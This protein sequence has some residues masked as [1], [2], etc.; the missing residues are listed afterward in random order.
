MYDL[1]IKDGQV[2][3]GSGQPLR[4]ADVAISKD[5]IARIGTV[6]SK[7]AS[8]VID[9][10]GRVVSPGFIDIHSHAD[11]TLP[12]EPEAAS[13][14]HQGIT[15]AVVGH[16]GH[17]LAPLLDKT[18]TEVIATQTPQGLTLPW[19]KWSTYGS[20]LDYLMELKISVNVVPLV[21]QGTIRGSVMG[22][23]ARR[24]TSQ[25]VTRMQAEVT[26]ALEAGSFGLSTGLEYPPGSYAQLEELMQV[27]QPLAKERA[28]YFSHLR[29]EGPQLVEAVKEAV[30]VGR[31]TGALVEI[32]HLKACWPG[33]E[34]QD[35]ALDIIGQAQAEGIDVAFDVYPYLASSTSLTLVLPHWVQEGGKTLTLNRLKDETVRRQI[36]CE[37]RAGS[38][39]RPMDWTQVM[40]SGS[41]RSEDEGLFVSELAERTGKEPEDWVFDA[42]LDAVLEIRIVRF[43]MKEENLRELLRH[44]SA[45][46]GSDSFALAVEGP[47]AKGKPHPRNFGTF[48]RVLGHYVR[49]E[50]V[51]RLEEAVHKMTGLPASRLGLHRRGLIREGC[52]ADLVIFDP[53]KISDEATYVSPFRYP[54]GIEKVIVNGNPVL[55]GGLHTHARPGLVLKR[56]KP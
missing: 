11:L 10:R 29:N 7:E 38:F 52:F 51:L 14:I 9:A 28:F 23:V 50:K 16:C 37:M 31:E 25:E 3:D 13:L 32:S 21:G 49:E 45:A 34:N 47:L 20:F 18:R 4:Q 5:T 15:T 24:P 53:E 44:R 48:P 12:I 55:E 35:R 43:T 36:A 8:R 27:T 39:G 42:L 46:I 33:W 6:E 22:F 1:L 56:N 26:K 19:E 40:I 54:A 2:S 41:P 30:S 17:T